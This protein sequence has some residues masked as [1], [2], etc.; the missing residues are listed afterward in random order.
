MEAPTS[1]FVRRCCKF[2]G[3][4]NLFV[5]FHGSIFMEG[6]IAVFARKKMDAL[7]DGEGDPKV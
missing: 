7:S 4:E 5:G 6:G 2:T 3:V 1:F